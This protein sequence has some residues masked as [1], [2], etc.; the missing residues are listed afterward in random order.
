MY[1][2]CKNQA[3]NINVCPVSSNWGLKLT[4]KDDMHVGSD[5]PQCQHKKVG[6]LSSYVT[7][8]AFV[9]RMSRN[10]LLLVLGRISKLGMLMFAY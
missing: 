1:V 2:W 9:T 10:G 6:V 5:H 8:N 3:L 4:I 7:G